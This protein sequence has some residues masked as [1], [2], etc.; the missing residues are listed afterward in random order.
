MD[1]KLNKQ[2]ALK[3]YFPL[4]LHHP[5]W[6]TKMG[7]ESLSRV[8]FRDVTLQRPL[9]SKDFKLSPPR[10][11]FAA[12]A[13]IKSCRKT[14]RKTEVVKWQRK[15]GTAMLLKNKENEA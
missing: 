12:A 1:R 4:H 8:K 6:P 15:N 11:C 14:K 3:M 2:L 10:I 7:N 5:C 13:K 9:C